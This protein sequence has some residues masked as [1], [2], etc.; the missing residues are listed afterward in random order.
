MS[1]GI[2]WWNLEAGLAELAANR[3]QLAEEAEDAEKTRSLTE[4]EAEA[5]E[6]DAALMQYV[7]QI[8]EKVDNIHALLLWARTMENA[9]ND[10]VRKRS[11]AVRRLRAMQDR[12]KA[13]ALQV[14][15]A[16]GIKK[17]VGTAGRYLLRKGNGGIQAL[18]IDGI[19]ENGQFLATSPLPSAYRDVVVRM[20]QVMWDRLRLLFEVPDFAV[21]VVPAQDRIREAMEKPC[22][23]CE[24]GKEGGVTCTECGGTCKARV[25]GARLLDRGEHLEVKG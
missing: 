14:M 1:G 20:P 18:Q 4:I 8:L 16:R 24:D 22:D 11:Q 15:E 21:T 5:A 17:A 3:M 7:G 9:A 13:M 19:G 12:I 25:P 6:V 2:T 10:E 23:W